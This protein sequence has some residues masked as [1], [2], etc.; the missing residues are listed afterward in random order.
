M[1]M[2]MGLQVTIWKMKGK[3]TQCWWKI[4]RMFHAYIIQLNFRKLQTKT[5]NLPNLLS[6]SILCLLDFLIFKHAKSWSASSWR[7]LI[8][9]GL[10]YIVKKQKGALRR[11]GIDYRLGIEKALQKI[12]NNKREKPNIGKNIL[13]C[14]WSM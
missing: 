6:V 11:L 9:S 1:S 2:K 10:S 5:S 12:L 8:S 13:W 7:D 14:F 3:K 4:L